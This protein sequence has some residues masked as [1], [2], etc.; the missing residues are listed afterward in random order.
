MRSLY[1]ITVV[2]AHD[3]KAEKVYLVSVNGAGLKGAIKKAKH[4]WK[5]DTW[6]RNPF[7]QSIN[8]LGKH[9]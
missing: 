6:E 5:K 1:E 8:F 2:A 7:I 4:Q 3:K 9:I